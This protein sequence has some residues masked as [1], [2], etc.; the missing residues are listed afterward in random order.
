MSGR[1]LAALLS[2]LGVMLFM[3]VPATGQ[4]HPSQTPAAKW[5][6]P[7]TPWGDPDLQGTGTT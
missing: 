1:S 5:E 6:Q 7:H 2:L 3:P 4:V